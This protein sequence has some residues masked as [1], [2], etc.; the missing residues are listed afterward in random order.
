MSDL[1]TRIRAFVGELMGAAPIAPPFPAGVAA[2]RQQP[3]PP[4]RRLMLAVI[5]GVILIAAALVVIANQHRSARVQIN[6]GPT[7]TTTAHGDALG[8]REVLS[9]YPYRGGLSQQS[10]PGA[11]S[12]TETSCGGGAL[13]TPPAK[14]TPSGSVV[15]PDR[16][17]SACYLLGP[18]LLTGH[19]ISTADATIDPTSA[20]WIINLHFANNDFVTKVADPYAG[21]QIAIVLDGVVESAPQINPGIT[22]QDV[23]ISG[24]YDEA[25]AKRVASSIAPP[26]P[27]A[28]TT[29]TD[30]NTNQ[31]EAFSAE[32]AKVA[33]RLGFDGRT[34]GTSEIRAG[35]A[36]AAFGRAHQQVPSALAT[37][38]GTRLLAM[39]EFTP[40]QSG[41]TPTSVCPNGTAVDVGP[42]I[43]YAVD[44]DLNA[45]RLPGVKYLFALPPGVTPNP[46]PDVCRLS[47]P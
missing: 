3:S 20:A 37:I 2:T 28:T 29:P 43:L 4:R 15:L 18:I 26:S 14:Q 46:Q 45:T 6:Q 34:T 8:F 12:S 1:D 31:L 24:S 10:N 21:R 5:G 19:N 27:D 39:C 22:G 9:T 30:P 13:V 41:V 47:S 42:L 23:T 36:R 11:V 17:K 25:T 16:N 38:D 33:P 7:T 35:D 44:A 40:T 32:C